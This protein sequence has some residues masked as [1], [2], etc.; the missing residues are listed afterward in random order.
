MKLF[1]NI[2]LL[3]DTKFTCRTKSDLIAHEKSSMQDL[4]HFSAQKKQY[5]QSPVIFDSQV[6]SCLEYPLEN[7]VLLYLSHPLLKYSKNFFLDG[8]RPT[9]SALAKFTLD[10]HQIKTVKAWD[11]LGLAKKVMFDRNHYCKLKLLQKLIKYLS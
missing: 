1:L 10:L 9:S 8:P 5:I 4:V 6:R 2:T 11:S 3:I 7:K